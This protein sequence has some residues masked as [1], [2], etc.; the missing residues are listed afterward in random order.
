M[1]LY[2]WHMPALLGMHLL[3]DYVGHPRYPGQPDFLV[4]S[5]M[6][7]L[8]MVA[9]V[10]V[11]FLLLRPLENNPLPGWDGAPNITSVGRGWRSDCHC[12]GPGWRRWP[13]SSGAS[14]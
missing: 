3:F 9:A 2:L 4:V 14:G 11:L 6:Q 7:V 12:V 5:V 10:A 8:L 13:R 1:T